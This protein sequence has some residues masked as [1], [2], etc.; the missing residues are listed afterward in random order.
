MPVAL[1]L[2]CHCLQRPGEPFGRGL[3]LHDPFLLARASPVVRES[4]EWKT[5][6]RSPAS[7]SPGGTKWNIRV[8]SGCTV[9][10]YR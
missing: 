2:G 9:S 8:V 1:A 6:P 7:V 3:P 5:R 4:Q 10:P